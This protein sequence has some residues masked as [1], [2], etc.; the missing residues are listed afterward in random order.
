MK[1]VEQVV[2]TEELTSQS[3]SKLA[4]AEDESIQWMDMEA[5]AKAANKTQQGVS[6]LMNKGRLKEFRDEGRRIKKT[7][8]WYLDASL[9]E[10]VK[11]EKA[12]KT[13]GEVEALNNQ[14]RSVQTALVKYR[15]FE[16]RIE[17][18]E[19]ENSQLSQQVQE[20]LQSTEE[21]LATLQFEKNSLEEKVEQLAQVLESQVTKPW[22]KIW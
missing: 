8:K 1:E 2:Q 16:N 6:Y 18:L 12:L 22:W 13:V 11:T 10:L 9:V 21:K 14:L 20:L 4:Q 17:I 3:L 15:D 5:F 7:D 19:S